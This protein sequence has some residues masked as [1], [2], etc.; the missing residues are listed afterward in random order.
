M[1]ELTSSD[2]QRWL[3]M[4]A[5]DQSSLSVYA[6]QRLTELELLQGLLVPSANNYAEIL[7]AWDAG[8]LGA[9]STR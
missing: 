7:A 8:S 1:I 4:V 6:G 2:E 9:F 3:E 5:E